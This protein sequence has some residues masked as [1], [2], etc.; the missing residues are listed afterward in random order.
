MSKV[1]L[2]FNAGAVCCKEAVDELCKWTA[3]GNPS[4]LHSDGQQAAEMVAKFRKYLLRLCK[5]PAGTYRVIFTS[6]AT[7]SNAHAIRGMIEAVQNKLHIKPHIISSSYEHKSI[8]M[9]LDYLSRTGRADVSLV[10][11]RIDGL[12]HISDI[13]REIRPTTA[14][15]SIIAAHNETG[16]INDIA[17]IGEMT[18]R[19][20]I[21]FHTDCTQYFGKFAV[22][23]SRESIDMVSISFHKL[24]APVGIGALIIR[25]KLLTDYDFPPI[26]FGAQEDGLRGGTTN[27]PLIAAA[28]V[29]TR[30]NFADRTLRNRKLLQLRTRLLTKLR[31]NFPTMILKD[32]IKT[33]PSDDVAIVIL[34]PLS[35]CLPNTLLFAVYR[36][37]GICNVIMQRE[38]EKRYKII[39]GIGSACNSGL[40]KLGLEKSGLEK[41]GLKAAAPDGTLAALGVPKELQSGVLRVSMNDSCCG[42]KNIDQLV[43]A[44]KSIVYNWARS[45]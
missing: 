43:A 37:D 16:A 17:A 36:R 35:D 7:E 13:E 41:S 6:G 40:K 34:S 45:K 27:A 24:C 22:H 29:A 3:C 9:L 11:P 19:R 30:L 10:M 38:L 23:P 44:L 14:L 25:E 31:D 20:G 28:E 39:I 8:S 21:A 15:I 1:L 32:Y 18:K 12:I 26:I 4:A 2:D 42:Q 5:I 33:P